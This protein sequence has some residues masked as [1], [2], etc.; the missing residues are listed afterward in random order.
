MSAKKSNSQIATNQP[1]RTELRKKLARDIA[2]I[3]ANPETPTVIYNGLG[4]TMNELHNNIPGARLDQSEAYNLALLDA[5]F[6]A[7]QK[8]GLR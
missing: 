3:F 6:E 5:Y 8:G 1:N 7:E 2:A 4:D